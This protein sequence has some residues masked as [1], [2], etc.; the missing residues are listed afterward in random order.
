MK[1]LLLMRHAKSSWK[2]DALPDHDR[3]LNKRGKHDAPKMGKLLREQDL[4][5]DLILCSTAVRA[6]QTA[7]AVL[8]E[9]GGDAEIHRHPEIYD[10]GEDDVLE[11]LRALPDEVERVLLIGHNPGLEVLVEMLSAESAAMPTAAVAHIE[12]DIAHWQKLCEVT[13]G[14][15]KGYWAPRELN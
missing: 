14:R 2:D 9:C 4:V 10:G 8:D 15:L 11:I 7:K 6:T 13:C 12:L 3:P 1:T 5:P